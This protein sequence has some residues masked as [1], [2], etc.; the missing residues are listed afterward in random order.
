MPR[1]LTQIDTFAQKLIEELPP[2]QRP[3]PGEQTYVA[4]SARLIHQ[5][6]QKYCQETGTNPPQVDTIR[7]WFYYPTPRWA[8]AVL[9]H[10]IKLHVVA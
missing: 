6:L 5:A 10:A 1:K 9:H 3:Y 8:I 4:T 7:N 2:S